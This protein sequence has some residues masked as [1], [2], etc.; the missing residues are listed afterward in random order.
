MTADFSQAKKHVSAIK[1]EQKRHA[2]AVEREKQ[3]HAE[4]LAALEKAE[5]SPAA[6]A[7][8]DVVLQHEAAQQNG[9]AVIFPG[10]KINVTTTAHTKWS[11]TGEPTPVPDLEPEVPE[12]LRTPPPDSPPGAVV[13]VE[14]HP[15]RRHR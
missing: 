2:E 5:L 11:P 3:N 7:L 4:R 14:S 10:E 8:V 9:A 15:V 13:V 1:R 12:R 6:R